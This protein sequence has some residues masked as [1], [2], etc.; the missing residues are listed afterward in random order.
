MLCFLL[1]RRFLQQFE[2]RMVAMERTHSNLW[3]R[4]AEKVDVEVLKKMLSQQ[5][6]D[7]SVLKDIV[8]DEVSAKVRPLRGCAGGGGGWGGASSIDAVKANAARNRGRPRTRVV[9]VAAAGGG[10]SCLSP[11]ILRLAQKQRPVATQGKV[12]VA[13]GLREEQKESLSTGRAARE[14]CCPRMLS[15]HS[16]SLSTATNHSPSAPV[17]RVTA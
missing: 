16:Y 17:P 11:S 4:K 7:T 2:K 15:A 13:V 1:S 10:Y 6:M 8:A 9:S 14:L 3:H 5:R 12:G